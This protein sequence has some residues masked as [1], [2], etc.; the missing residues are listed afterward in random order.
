M[1]GRKMELRLGANES[2]FGLSPSAQRAM[3]KAVATVGW[4]GDPESYDLREELAGI[5]GVTL[6]NV[7]VGAGLDELLGLCAK[8][9]LEPGDRVVNS[10]GGYPT[11]N[12]VAQGMGAELDLVP[13]KNDRVDL[14]GLALVARERGAKIIYIANPDNPSGS[15][16]TTPEIAQLV[17]AMPPDCILLLDEAYY[18]FAPPEA[19]PPIDVTDE[20]VIRLRTFSK[21]HGMAG[22]RVGYAFAT[23]EIINAF[24]RVRMHFEVNRVAQIG[25]LASLRD[26]AFV[27]SVAD[28]VATGRHDYHKLAAHLGLKSLP[29]STNFVLIDLG[30]FERAKATLDALLKRGVFIRMPGAAPLNRCIRVTVGTA[31][32]R[33]AFAKHLA[34]AL[35]ETTATV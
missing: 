26:P 5:Y 30:S 20:R 12:Y 35:A 21:A 23:S 34:E 31:S 25:A 10:L 33:A 28:E 16:C 3:E 7:V 24:N 32:E 22:A 2:S 15:W 4:Y 1:L 13:Y 18:D 29:S 27:S 19:I 11:F 17:E 8:T 6:E 14:E 9:F